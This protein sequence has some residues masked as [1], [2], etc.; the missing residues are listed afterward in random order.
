MGDLS[1][2]ALPLMKEDG[3]HLPDRGSLS[4]GTVCVK[5]RGPGSVGPLDALSWLDCIVGDEGFII[6]PVGMQTAS[7]FEQNFLPD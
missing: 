7:I 4:E 2:R 3:P 5:S 1:P 6:E